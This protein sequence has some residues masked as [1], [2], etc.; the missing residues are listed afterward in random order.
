MAPDTTLTPDAA[1]AMLALVKEL[2]RVIARSLS[3]DPGRVDAARTTMSRLQERLRA[4]GIDVDDRVGTFP[5]RLAELRRGARKD[6]D[7]R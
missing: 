6:D 3:A 4:A 5:E 1:T 7:S 2:P